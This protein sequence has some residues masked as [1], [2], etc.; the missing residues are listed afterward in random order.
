MKKG[1]ENLKKGLTDLP[2]PA[3]GAVDAVDDIATSLTDV[4]KAAVDAT[5]AFGNAFEDLLLNTKDVG[6]II[7]SMLDEIGRALVRNLVIGPMIKGLQGA[8]GIPALASA[9]GNVFSSSAV[10]PFASGG[11]VTGPF[12]FGLSG[13]RLG[14]MGEKGTEAVMP[15]SRNDKG[16]LGVKM[17][18]GNRTSV[19]MNIT[20]PNPDSFRRSASQIMRRVRSELGRA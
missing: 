15:L 12:L 20:T 9:N 6:S 2:S 11:V 5:T 7:K 3:N 13:R 1:L 17:A 14:L 4:Q 16:E 10:V 18:G 19:V 8:M